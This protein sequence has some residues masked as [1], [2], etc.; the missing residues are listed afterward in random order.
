MQEPA[1]RFADD[2]L[3]MRMDYLEP[4]IHKPATP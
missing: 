3:V 1:R 4:I 2:T